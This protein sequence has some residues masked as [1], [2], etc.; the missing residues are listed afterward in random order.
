MPFDVCIENIY[1]S[2]RAKKSAIPHEIPTY[3]WR[4]GMVID[5]SPLIFDLS[6]GSD[7]I[8]AWKQTQVLQCTLFHL[9]FIFDSVLGPPFV[10][11]FSKQD[12]ASWNTWDLKLEPSDVA[13]HSYKKSMRV[14]VSPSVHAAESFWVVGAK[15]EGVDI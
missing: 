5:G 8:R 1:I 12:A 4:I 15:A 14:F 13:L 3:P 11:I 6:D 10:R 2:L 9:L 7:M